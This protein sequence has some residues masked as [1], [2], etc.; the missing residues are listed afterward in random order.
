MDEVGMDDVKMDDSK[1]LPMRAVADDCAMLL[2]FM[3]IESHRC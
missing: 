2:E 1:H 3:Q